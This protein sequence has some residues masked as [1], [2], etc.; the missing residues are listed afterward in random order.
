MTTKIYAHKNS[1]HEYYFEEYPEWKT[2]RHLLIGKWFVVHYLKPGTLEEFG[3]GER[4]CEKYLKEV[5]L[6]PERARVVGSYEE[7]LA[8]EQFKARQKREELVAFASTKLG[9]PLDV[10]GD[11]SSYLSLEMLEAIKR[12][13]S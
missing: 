3:F 7:R 10:E 1:T 5:K 11:D 8:V 6:D 9:L 4:V 13:F 12:A 2:D